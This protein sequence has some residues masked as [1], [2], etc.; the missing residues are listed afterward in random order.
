MDESGFV[1]GKF[2]KQNE[3]KFITCDGRRS[4]LS[5]AYMTHP[6]QMIPWIVL[7]ISIGVTSIC[8]AF[9]VRRRKVVDNT[10]FQF[11]AI[12]M[13]QG[14]NVGD[15]LKFCAPFVCSFCPFL[16]MAFVLSSGYK[17][18]VITGECAYDY[19]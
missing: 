5:F 1:V 9:L 12:L 14:V 13:E 10:I 2:G 8:A 7:V 18:L 11:Y 17:G 4:F 19:L 3:V 6:F 15:K 16:F